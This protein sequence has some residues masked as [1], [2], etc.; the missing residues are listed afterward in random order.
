M[1]F[2]YPVFLDVSGKKCLIIGEGRELAAKAGALLDAG[3]NVTRLNSGAL[4]P[5]HLDGCFLIITNQPDNA[6]VFRLAEERNILC[7]AVDDPARC[8]FS[9]GA[10]HRQGDLTI[11]ISTN[12]QSPALAVRLKE[13]FQR[14]IGPEYGDLLEVL[15]A[16]RA[17]IANRVPDFAAR[18]ELWYRLVDSDVLG[19][20][21]TG[22]RDAAVRVLREM[23][24]AAAVK[25]ME[26][27]NEFKDGPRD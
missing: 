15:T 26:A 11:A 25:M 22:K 14:E 20:L 18:R 1:N 24:E 16:V 9:F 6:E 13:Q 19:L 7:N 10:V 8:R 21:R 17:E 4:R 12:G 3:A 27:P 2:R 5:E 23:I